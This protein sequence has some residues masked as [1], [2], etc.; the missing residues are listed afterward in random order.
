[1]K[2]FFKGVWRLHSATVAECAKAVFGLAAVVCIAAVVVM[3]GCF[4]V[5]GFTELVMDRVP[6]PASMWAEDLG[7]APLWAIW[8]MFYM[9]TVAAG[10]GFYLLLVCTMTVGRKELDKKIRYSVQKATAFYKQC[11]EA[12]SAR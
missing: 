7:A 11:R 1:M 4:W 3:V 6:T 8:V 2:T 9:F 12:G 5:V 10:I